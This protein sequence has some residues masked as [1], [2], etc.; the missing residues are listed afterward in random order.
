M[1]VSTPIDGLIV[2]PLTVHHDDRGYLME[3]LRD[4]SPTFTKFGQVYMVGDMVRGTVRAFH[5]HRELIDWFFISHG[6]AKFVFVDGRNDSPTFMKY[7]VVV[8]GERRPVCITVPPGV[9]HG[10]M[11]LDDDTQLI[12]VANSSHDPNKLD[13]ER[14][15]PNFFDYVKK[16][17]WEVEF[18]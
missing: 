17:F 7:Q 14:V 11:S 3:I 15:P 18:K 10:W 5:R 8:A 1:S 9:W 4:D 12:S 16:G 6:T 2:R 13:E